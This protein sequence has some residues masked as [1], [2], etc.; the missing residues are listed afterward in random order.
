MVL[1]LLGVSMIYYFGWKGYTPDQMRQHLAAFF[2]IP[3]TPQGSSG[4]PSDLGNVPGSNGNVNIPPVPVGPVTTPGIQVD[5]DCTPQPGDTRI[6]PFI[7][8]PIGSGWI[9]QVNGK[10][11]GPCP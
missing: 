4:T 1:A 6:G 5:N 2:G 7:W 8:R 3:T 10:L 11:I 9:G